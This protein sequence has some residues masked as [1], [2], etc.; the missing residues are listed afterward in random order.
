MSKPTLEC[1]EDRLTPA[2]IYGLVPSFGLGG[3]VRTS[4]IHV[5]NSVA[6]GVAVQADGKVVAVG[7]VGTDINAGNGFLVTRYNADGR[8]DA[9]FGPHQDGQVLTYFNDPAVATSVA[10]QSDGKIVVGGYTSTAEHASGDFAAVRYNEDGSLDT[11]FGTGGVITTSF[12]T[13]GIGALDVAKSIVIDS[14]GRIVLAGYTG[15]SIETSLVGETSPSDFA[16]VRYTAGGKLDTTFGTGG[17]VITS[18]GENSQC[19]IN[20]VT[21]DAQGR[22][23]VAGFNATGHDDKYNLARR[24]AL[25]RYSTNGNLD[26]TFGKGGEVTTNV[27]AGNDDDASGVVIQPNG[28]IVAAGWSYNPDTRAQLF[29]LARYTVGGSLDTTFGKGGTV[30]TDLGGNHDSR[31]N[32]VALDSL[33]RIVVTGLTLFSPSAGSPKSYASVVAARYKTNGGLDTSFGNGGEAITGLGGKAWLGQDIALAPNGQILVAG[34]GTVSVGYGFGMDFVLERLN[35]SGKLDSTFGKGGLVSLPFN[36]GVNSTLDALA[37]GPDGKLV[38]VGDLP[39]EGE[40]VGILRFNKNGVPDSTFGTG[41]QVLTRIDFLGSTDHVA[42][43]VVQPDGKIVVATVFGPAGFD[44]GGSVSLLRFNADGSVDTGFGVDGQIP[45][46]PLP[47]R[48]AA[49]APSVTTAGIVVQPDGKILVAVGASSLDLVRFDRNGSLDT[50][51]GA[52]HT[53]SIVTVFPVGATS[54]LAL[55]PNGRI[56]VTGS[57]NGDLG[58]ARYNANGNL[59]RTFGTSGVVHTNIASIGVAGVITLP[60]GQVVVGG[61]LRAQDDF[62]LARFNANGSLDRTFGTDGQTVTDF[63]GNDTATSVVIDSAG[64]IVLAG[65]R[66]S[67]TVSIPIYVARYTSN[68]QLDTHFGSGGKLSTIFQQADPISAGLTLVLEPRGRLVVAGTDNGPALGGSG[69]TLTEYATG[70]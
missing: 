32:A 37:V 2:P 13:L 6:N 42:G 54:R 56:M 8:P 1:L 44:A 53:G 14:A 7:T 21:L 17:K 24:F 43:N 10:L 69:I 25:A 15:A 39:N 45:L 11:T 3:S 38:V 40:N 28:K 19:A 4:F 52:N 46:V 47:A 30:V 9:S 57:V 67:M 65:F 36:G 70:S 12:G 27:V 50:T 60:G 5:V 66:S 41:G 26:T 59:D 64:G 62:Y 61:T 51:F 49:M 58:L 33:G 55:K 23:V 35:P 29:A 63:G 68:G 48:Q 16:L 31:I 18:V 22:I 34:I 20:A